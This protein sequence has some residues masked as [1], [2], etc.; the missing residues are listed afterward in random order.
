[1][2]LI[3]EHTDNLNSAVE[4]N[5][6]KGEEKEKDKNKESENKINV[7]DKIE[8][9]T[10]GTNEKEEEDK[11]LI[12]DFHV[13][14]VD[15]EKE[16]GNEKDKYGTVDHHVISIDNRPAIIN[17]IKKIIDDLLVNEKN[18]TNTVPAL[19]EEDTILNISS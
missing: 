7:T 3:V 18:E 4:D 11:D 13:I 14:N 15:K 10:E 2:T 16:K 17:G 1:M 19:I 8:K 6:T 5:E 12:V 9:E